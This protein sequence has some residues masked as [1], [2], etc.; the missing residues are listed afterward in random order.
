M[1]P[2]Q[3][4]AHFDRLVEA[5]NA[6]P[7][8]RRFV[9]NLAVRGKLVEQDPNDEP[10][11]EL[12]NRI[13]A[14]KSRL[15]KSGQIRKRDSQRFLTNEDVRFEVPKVW[16]WTR[17][18]EVGDWGSGSTPPRGSHEYFGGNISWFK[19]GEL[20]DNEAL[21]GSEEKLT[22]LALSKCSFRK[23]SP[24]DILF[25]MYGATIG[26]V[27]I[28]AEHAVT[29]QAV[30]GCSPFTGVSN[31]YL[32]KFLLAQREQFH[33]VSEGGAQP[34]VSKEKM[35]RCP[36]PLPPLAE[37]HRIV[38]KVDELMGLCDR[39][40]AAQAQ[41]ERRRDRLAAAS[42]NRLN[43]P[44]DDAKAFRTHAC[45]HLCHL[46]RFTIRP[47]QIPALRQTILN[48]AVRGRLV[49]QDPHDEP[50]S[51]LLKRIQAEKARQVKDG[52]AKRVPLLDP[53]G[54]DEVL[55][56]LPCSWAL[57]RAGG[58]CHS[59]SSGATPSAEEFRGD[60]GVPFLKVYNIRDQKIDFEYRKQFITLQYHAE[61]MRRSKL[62]PGNVI[63]NIVGPPLG[64]VAII[65]NDYEE[66]NCNQAIAFFRPIE[67]EL[68][69]Y[70]YLFIKEGSFLKKISLVGTAGQDNI[71]VTKC[72]NIVIPLPPLV[73]QH[74]IVAKVGELMGV[75]DRLELQLTTAQ[76]ESRR[77]L[78][79]VLHEALVA[80]SGTQDGAGRNGR[81]GGQSP[82][83]VNPK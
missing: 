35:V 28:L 33:L 72:K 83:I 78:E 73:E 24:G 64:K 38:A 42:L 10:A 18:G 9:L 13:Q 54:E 61:K 16:A 36:F 5:P 67:P 32:F 59:V 75:C 77:L 55:F 70:I 60:T 6:V 71:S 21:A 57:I 82:A 11:C 26:K 34:N 50:A 1:N 53:I 23:N 69:A 46:P 74:R 52:K 68:S 31:R 48:L 65:P 2:A 62:F 56:P 51:E 80:G 25:A 14:E 40:E 39:L 22:T 44:D 79:A 19:S 4:L 15:V 58:I 43:R 45:F 29:N 30:V 3:L 27:A 12:L 76:T 7:R 17:L 63:M 37:Q 66:W 81:S 41:R 20:N 8:L 49:R 47:D